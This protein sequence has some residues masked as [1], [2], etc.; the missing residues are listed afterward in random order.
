MSALAKRNCRKKLSFK[1]IP[2]AAVQQAHYLIHNKLMLHAYQ[3]EE[4]G[5]FHLAGEESVQRAAKLK[6][7]NGG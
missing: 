5:L 7:K 6:E 3:C 4:C 2:D 1:S